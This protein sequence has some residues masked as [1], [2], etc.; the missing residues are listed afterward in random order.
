MLMDSVLGFGGIEIIENPHMVDKIRVR[1]HKKK[2]IDKKWLKRYG[3]RYVP[4][5]QFLMMKETT[6]RIKVFAHP[7]YAEEIRTALEIERMMKK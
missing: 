4:Q 3:Y 6:G 2:R 7:K 5:K 1:R